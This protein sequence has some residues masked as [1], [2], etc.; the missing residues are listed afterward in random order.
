MP[1]V[2]PNG[3]AVELD[4]AGD[5]RAPAGAS[6]NLEFDPATTADVRQ[7]TVAA[8]GAVV[9]SP[10]VVG[11]P[12]ARARGFNASAFGRVSVGTDTPKIAPA[13]IDSTITVG[14]PEYVR[15]P[16]YADPASINPPIW[17]L[18]TLRIRLMGGYNPPPADSLVLNW[19]AEPYAPPPATS[20]KLEFGALGYGH[21]WPAMGDVSA[22]G[23]AT[24]AMPV[25]LRPAGIAPP[26]GSPPRPPPSG[27]RSHARPGGRRCAPGE[28][29][30]TGARRRAG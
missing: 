9:G 28:D 4:L 15:W 1:Y 25:G 23:S 13:G 19:F 21:V 3:S 27:A 12:L 18:G 14:T 10:Q 29:A 17:P 26:P 30:P 20:L 24:V 11:T 7:A 16:K 6:I 8:S 5:Y 2:P 22:F